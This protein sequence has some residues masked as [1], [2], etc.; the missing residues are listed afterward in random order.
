MIMKYIIIRTSANASCYAIE[1]CPPP[2]PPKAEMGIRKQFAH[3]VVLLTLPDIF[4][5]CEYWSDVFM[6]FFYDVSCVF[7]DY[8][9]IV[10]C[11][12]P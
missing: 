7:S 8:C 4:Q 6:A 5:D 1:Q 12:K 3:T 9:G 11:S 10:K 2:P